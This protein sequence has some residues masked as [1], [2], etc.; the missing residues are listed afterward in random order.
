MFSNNLLMAAA[1]GQKL[2][3]DAATITFTASAVSAS[4]LTTYTFSSQNIGTAN[5]YRR[6][7]IGVGSPHA[8]QPGHVVSSVTVGGVAAVLEKGYTQTGGVAETR[9]EIWITPYITTGTAEDVVVVFD[10]AVQS[11]GIGV[12]D[13]RN[14]QG[15]ATDTAQGIWSIS[16]IDV[17]AEGVCLAVGGIVSGSTMT[18]TTTGLTE[19]YDTYI[20]YQKQVRGSSLAFASETLG[21]AITTAD[22]GAADSAG[23]V[24]CSFR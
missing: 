2:V 8:A 16:S 1:A 13:I 7:G 21:L 11:C 5:A 9:V 14:T 17:E 23:I 3:L 20:E 4:N 15:S 18:T 19:R 12:Y 24:A 22:Y 10:Q 6:I